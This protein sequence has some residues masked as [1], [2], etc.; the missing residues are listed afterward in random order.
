MLGYTSVFIPEWAA[1]DDGPGLAVM[2]A[3]NSYQAPSRVFEVP[4]T[5]PIVRTRLFS[6]DKARLTR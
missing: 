6:E 2:R 5:P 4:G 1:T 3:H